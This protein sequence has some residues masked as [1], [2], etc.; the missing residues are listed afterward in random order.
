MKSGTVFLNHGSFGACPRPVLERQAELRR[1]MEAEPVQFLWRNYEK[2][3]QPARSAVARFVHARARDV[4]FVSNATTGINAV[5]RSLRFQ[6]GDEILTTSHD[7]NACHNVLIEAA[8]RA[9]ARLVVAQIPF[10]LPD[11]DTAVEAILA[12]ITRRT[13]L[14]M[15]DHVTSSTALVLPIARIVRELE[16]RHI[17][18]L[19]DGAHAPGSVPLNLARL[20]PAY[21]T[22][23]LHKWVCA[24]KGAL[25]WQAPAPLS[26]YFRPDLQLDSRLR[27]PGGRAAAPCLVSTS[28]KKQRVRHLLS[29]GSDKAGPAILAV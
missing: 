13:R 4:V 6:P 14:A 15:I 17:D 25:D 7:Y 21:Y 22:A 5:L 20:A 18:T 11:A 12:A 9:R 19:V 26:P 3:L 8:R 29:I 28:H 23:N 24:P 1:A 16:A 2:H 27:I 10:P